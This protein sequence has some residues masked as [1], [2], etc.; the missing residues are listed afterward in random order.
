MF[1]Q[2]SDPGPSW[3]SCSGCNGNRNKNNLEITSKSSPPKV[4]T[5]LSWNFISSI[6]VIWGTNDNYD[7]IIFLISMK[8]KSF[9]PE[10]INLKKY[11]KIFS[12]KTTDQIIMKLYVHHQGDIGNK[13]YSTAFRLIIVLVAMAKERQN[14]WKQIKNLPLRNYWP[15]SYGTLLAVSVWYG[16]RTIKNRIFILSCF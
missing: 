12:S 2:V 13:R 15:D 5:R 9:F 3:P 8:W 16:V 11:L 10:R 7:F 1:S 6:S 14:L 4:L